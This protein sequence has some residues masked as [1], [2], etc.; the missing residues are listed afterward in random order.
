[1]PARPTVARL[2][3]II[4]ANFGDIYSD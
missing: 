4:V 2:N 3:E 1:L